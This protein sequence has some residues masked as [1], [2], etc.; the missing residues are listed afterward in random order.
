MPEVGI[1]GTPVIDLVSGTLYVD[2]FTGVVGGGVTN[3][4]HRLHALNITNGTE[5][6]NSPV[7]GQRQRSGRRGRQHGAAIPSSM[8]SSNFNAAH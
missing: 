2:A 6:P 1:T 3:Y 7:F 4:F 5:L 8:R